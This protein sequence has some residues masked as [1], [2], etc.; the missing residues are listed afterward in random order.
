MDTCYIICAGDAEIININK[1]KTDIIIAV[2]AGLR[3]CEHN[4]IEPDMILGDFDSLGFVPDSLNTVV[5]PVEKDDT[6]TF[7]AVKI[8]IEKGYDRFIFFGA[9]GGKRPE[10]TYANIACLA[11]LSKHGKSAF[12]D[13][14]QYTITAITNGK[15]VFPDYME[16]DISVFSFDNESVGVW[17][18][19]LLYSLTDAVINNYTVTGISNSFTGKESSISVKQGTLIIYYN[20]KPDDIKI[21]KNVV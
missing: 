5:L 19:G 15:A 4:N 17:E 14:G 10:H 2:D 12:M 9:S 16:G 3:H 11:Y 8:G 1:D 18:K 7:A 20:G 21:G 13:C 6:D